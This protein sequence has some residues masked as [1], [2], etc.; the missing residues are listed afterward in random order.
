MTGTRPGEG[1][2]RV[3]LAEGGGEPAGSPSCL[4]SSAA[5]RGPAV[6]AALV[7]LVLL[8]ERP[9]PVRARRRHHHAAASP[10][11]PRR[12][13]RA[14]LP[15]RRGL[16]GQP[17]GQRK[18]GNGTGTDP[19]DRPP[20]K[21]QRDGEGRAVRL[22]AIAPL[23]NERREAEPFVQRFIG[24]FFVQIFTQRG[25]QGLAALREGA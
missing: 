5:L 25:G 1:E 16:A 19:R 11:P 13:R 9:G 2:R 8:L 3:R 12:G 21:E 20:G 10:P 24:W 4:T 18:G 17:R 6:L 22:V 14:S 15:A 23:G 7:R